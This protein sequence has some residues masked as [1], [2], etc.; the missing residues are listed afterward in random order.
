VETD[1]AGSVSDSREIVP[2]RS[3][4]NRDLVDLGSTPLVL[5]RSDHPI[6]RKDIS[7]EALHVLTRLDRHGFKAYLVG[8]GVRDLFLG[9]KPADFDVGTDARPSKLKKIFHNS[10]VI[11][12]RFRIAHVFFPSGQIVEVA[13]FRQNSPRVLKTEGGIILRDNEYGT[14]EEDARRRDLTINGLFY[15][16]ATFSVIDFVGGV[17]DLRDGI[18]RTIAEPNES[19][20]E[21]PVRML[22]ALR[23]AVRTG[24]TVEERTLA[25]IHANGEG[26]TASNSARLLEELFKD[27]RSCCAMPFFSSLLQ[28]GLLDGILPALARQLR[29]AGLEHPFWRRLR[30]LDKRT[31]AGES[32]PTA[33]YLSVLL[34]T[35]ILPDPQLWAG[36][37]RNPP[38]VWNLAHSHLRDSTQG[39]RISRRDMERLAQIAISY[40]RLRQCI[41]RRHIQPALIEKPYVLDALDFAAVDLE[42]DEDAHPLVLEWRSEASRRREAASPPAGDTSSPEADSPE[43]DSPEADDT[44]RPRRR[45]RRR[46]GRRR[47][48]R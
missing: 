38:N 14:P 33:V 46:G 10:R 16:I 47:G 34:Q 37:G 9:K 3:P 4:L 40:R 29:E 45:R 23:H 25:A 18:I 41:E 27:L 32:F 17:Q 44:P 42:G 1:A 31:A 35:L 24:F 20:R 30:A 7:Q 15:D 5:P 19:F 28:T 21:D 13:T 39:F 11:G 48:R 26:I 8:G 12:R 2:A 43:A 36:T 22:R 6:S